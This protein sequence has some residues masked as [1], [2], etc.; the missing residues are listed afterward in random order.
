MDQMRRQEVP[1]SR[2][3][4]V[5]FQREFLSVFPDH[6]TQDDKGTV[7]LAVVDQQRMECK[8]IKKSYTDNILKKFKW[9]TVQVFPSYAEGK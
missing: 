2:K 6:Q 3:P 9:L 5:L 8:L 1:V 4:T 7:E